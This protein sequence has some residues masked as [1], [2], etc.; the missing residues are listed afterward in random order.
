MANIIH[1]SVTG[2]QQ[3]L[4]SAGCGTEKSIGNKWQ[5][6]HEDEIF[7]YEIANTVTSEDNLS[8]HPVTIRKPIDKATPLLLQALNDK[9]ML[10]C[11]F[12][13]YRTSAHGGNE[14]YFKMKLAKARIT[15]INY[16]YPNSVTHNDLQPQELISLRFATVTMEHTVAH[17][18]AWAS[19][20]GE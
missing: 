19:W 6:G 15:E 18:S 11:C 3:G 10:E 7:I 8:F 5:R 16:L 20:K 13:F 14:L 4:L 9:E 17:T 12:H 2:Y 1:L